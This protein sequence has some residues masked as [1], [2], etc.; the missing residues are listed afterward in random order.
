[1]KALAPAERLRH[2][3]SFTN[4]YLVETHGDANMFATVFLGI[5]NLQNGELT[6]I[7][8]G[9]EPPLLLGR[10]GR[11]TELRPTGPVVGMMP[12]AAFSIKEIALEKNDLLLTFTDGI[13]DA[14]NPEDDF[15]GSE[16]V[17]EL[18]NGDDSTPAVLLKNI[19]VSGLQ[20]SDYRK[21]M[22][23]RVADCYREVFGFF[24]NGKL[25]HR[26][27]VSTKGVPA[28]LDDR[29]QQAISRFPAEPAPSASG[30]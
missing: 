29:L 21:R 2:V 24:E 30:A 10:G 18:L 11:V 15:F 16:R 19:E 27:A 8:C 7:N 22:P 1:M 3:I 12:G 28:E 13:P 20:I 23:E 14:R 5:F 9:N 4:R 17:L 25:T 26:W 6:Y